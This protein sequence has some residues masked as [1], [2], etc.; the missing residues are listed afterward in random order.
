MSTDIRTGSRAEVEGGGGGNLPLPRR[1]AAP[2]PD[3]RLQLLAFGIARRV[4]RRRRRRGWPF[5]RMRS[6]LEEL[7]VACYK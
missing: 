5:T 2:F 1:L 4:R 6:A 3:E 7:V